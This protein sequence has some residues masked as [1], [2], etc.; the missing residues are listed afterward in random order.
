MI[1]TTYGEGGFCADCD[2]DAHGHPLHNVVS[3]EEVPDPPA[4]DPDVTELAAA[5]ANLPTDTLAAL[6]AALGLGG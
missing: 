6:R 2:P 5:L 4:A 1:E 3:V